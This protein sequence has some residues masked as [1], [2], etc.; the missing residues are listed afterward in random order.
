MRRA[1]HERSGRGVAWRLIAATAMVAAVFAA[2]A[3][4]DDDR[5]NIA[6]KSAADDAGD[7]PVER[8]AMAHDLM[9]A[10]QR[11]GDPMLAVAAVRLLAG[12]E[13][14]RRDLEPE[15]VEGGAAPEEGGGAVADR[16]AMIAHARAVTADDE[17]LAAILDETLATGTRGR[18]LN[19]IVVAGR[20]A[21]QGRV[22]YF[23]AEETAFDG[24]EVAEIS[25]IGTGVSDLD[26]YVIDEL[27][28]EIC[29]SVGYSDQEYCR[30]TPRWT[31]PFK[32][33]IV[34]AGNNASEFRLATN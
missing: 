26:L 2:S 22:L 20:V 25:I 9:R 6:P 18:T 27:D 1:P 31:G 10:S 16:D 3:Q 33:V 8:L 4:A 29:R 28:N 12:V 32:I 13:P 11:T 21:G 23:D 14:Q 19:P 15:S 17:V 30:W 34:N 24:G 5:R 7:R